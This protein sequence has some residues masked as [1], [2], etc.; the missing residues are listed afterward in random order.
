VKRVVIT[1]TC[2]AIIDWTK[3]DGEIDESQFAEVHENTR[4]YEKSKILAEKKAW[5]LIENPPEGKELELVVVNPALVMGKALFKSDFS[6]AGLAIKLMTGQM[7]KAPDVNVPFVD[8][9]D[10]ARGHVLAVD[11]PAGERY[12]LT[13]G[14]H[15]M[16]ELGQAFHKEFSSYGYQCTNDQMGYEFAKNLSEKVKELAFYV[17]IW[18]KK[19]VVKNDKSIEKLGMKEYKSL[20][21]SISEMG[22]SLIELGIV[23]DKTKE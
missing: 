13:E 19:I 5:E 12:A 7:A 2:L 20:E 17:S 18:G 6:S 21:K 16:V 4:L 9:E 23:E 1:S 11:A 8:V 22:W 3:E 15:Q 14:T 10:V